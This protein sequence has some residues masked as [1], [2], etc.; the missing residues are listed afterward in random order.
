MA[1]LADVGSFL[2]GSGSLVGGYLGYKGAKETN[3]ANI[4]SAREQMAF[5]ERMS[6]TAYSRAMRDMKRAGLNPMLAYAQGGASSPGGAMPVLKNPYEQAATGL[7]GLGQAVSSTAKSFSDAEK[8]KLET[9]IIV[10]KMANKMF[11]EINHIWASED[12]VKAEELK[13]RVETGLRE[14]EAGLKDL[15]LKAYRKLSSI[16]GIEVGP[17][18]AGKA[19][20]VIDSVAKIAAVIRSMF[21][22]FGGMND[23]TVV[24][25]FFDSRGN[26]K[27]GS[28]SK[29]K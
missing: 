20:Q 2:G 12:K 13:V 5:Q 27:G 18:S 16:L 11:A 4:A 26:V 1:N 17:D 14:I 24:K 15:D 23:R 7:Q 29:S 3:A 6:N 19:L 28:V 25:T 8:T 21:P 9:E 10:P 22:I